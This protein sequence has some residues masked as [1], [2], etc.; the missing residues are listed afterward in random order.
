MPKLF[1]KLTLSFLSALVVLFSLAPFFQA[2]AVGITV[3]PASLWSH[4]WYAEE[5]PFAWYQKV[6][7]ATTSPES[8][9]FGERYTAAQVQW[10]IYGVFSFFWNFIPGNPQLT[11]CALSGD[12]NSCAD[13]L[14]K[15]QSVIKISDAGGSN[16]ASTPMGVLSFI[17][18]NPVSTTAYFKDVAG[19]FSLVSTVKAQG[20]GYSVAGNSMIALW[21]ITRNLSYG[22][23]IL[24]V[25]VLAFMI[26]FRVKISPQVVISVQSALPK[27]VIALILI[28]FSYAIAGLLVDL[29]Y[30]VIGILAAALSGGGLSGENAIVLFKDF[31]TG[32][33]AIGLL[34]GYWVSFVIAAFMSIGSNGLTI[35]IL[36]GAL[37][38][39]FAILSILLILWWSIKIVWMLIKNYALIMITIALGPL[40]ILMGTVTG[41][42]G[43]GTWIKKMVSYLAVYPVMAL[44]FFL[45]FFFL[46]QGNNPGLNMGFLTPP[47]SP[48]TNIIG[49]NAWIPPLSIATESGSQL[50]WLFVSFFIFSE[51]TKVTEMIQ[52]FIAGKPFAF[53]SGIGEAMGPIGT[54]G[55]MA[56]NVVS[57]AQAGAY[58]R[59][60]A[61]GYT[62]TT[63]DIVN[64]VL[65]GL[66][67]IT[68][69]KIRRPQS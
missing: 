35:N 33:N 36:W 7:D 59:Q 10:V 51:I 49:T 50:I 28:T 58:E 56:G 65:N 3:D 26:M 19:R 14:Q 22:L 18:Q 55:I 52:A 61:S 69:G 24:A 66:G 39:I 54:S 68:G 16:F 23:I 1:K 37:A 60:R 15:L 17:G 46:H 41:A 62:S 40:E 21:R 63:A 12:I 27:V 11:T 44:L 2:K 38:F 4:T 34:Y 67:I 8:D 47:F 30:V 57:S 64:G 29:M 6:Y 31:T 42:M 9:I 32:Y 25:I 48:A 20:F 53:G 5:N 43:F 13:L 45:A